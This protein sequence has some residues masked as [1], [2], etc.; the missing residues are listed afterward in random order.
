MKYQCQ[1]CNFQWEGTSHTFDQV[2][3]HEESHFKKLISVRCKVCNTTNTDQS[4]T[5][6]ELEC[7]ICG[8]LIDSKGSVISTKK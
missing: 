4:N 3:E 8:N 7:K 6:R 1:Q 5:G 2:R